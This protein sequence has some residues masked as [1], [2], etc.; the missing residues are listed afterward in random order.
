[1][2]RMRLWDVDLCVRHVSSMRQM[3]DTEVN[4][5]NATENAWSS[6]MN[7]PNHRLWFSISLRIWRFF[8]NPWC[9]VSSS[10][11]RTCHDHQRQPRRGRA[12]PAAKRLWKKCVLLGRTLCC[13]ACVP[14]TESLLCR[15]PDHVVKLSVL[16]WRDIRHQPSHAVP[17]PR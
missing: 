9:L 14:R 5:S 10:D 12:S 2:S 15:F 3:K 17:T 13:H 1:M 11:G 7:T 4:G 6:E 16:H 8:K